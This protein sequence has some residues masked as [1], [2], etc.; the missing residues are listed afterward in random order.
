MPSPEDLVKEMLLY[1]LDP[2]DA[3]RNFVQFSKDDTT[4]LLINNFGG[5]SPLELEGLAQ[6]TLEQLAKDY[7]IKPA[8]IYVSTF[9]TS[10]NGPGFSLTLG[11]LSGIATATGKSLTDITALLDAPTNAPAWPRNHYGK[12]VQASAESAKRREASRAGA[13]AAAPITKPAAP[14]TFLPALRAACQAGI[15]AEPDITKYD[16]VMGDGDCGEGVLMAC[17]ALLKRFE[18]APF[19]DGTVALFPALDAILDVLED[20]GGSLFAILSIL[21]TAFVGNLKREAAG[22]DVTQDAVAK[23]A[24]AAIEN[25]FAYTGA[26]VGDRT[27]MDA[28]IPFCEAL[29]KEADVNKAVEAGNSG[30]KA[31][32]AMTPKFGR[33]TYIG[34]KEIGEQPPDPGAYAV[35]LWLAA[36]VGSWKA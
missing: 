28:L 11:N 6:V 14:A 35:A 3:E 12:A 1:V 16:M 7:S 4:C 22:G 13:D 23:A 9:E 32:A 15:K 20:M 33:A 25:L 8:R 31:T 5:L 34:D 24:G 2:N 26:R 19:T 29:G 10:L 18:T 30:A 36:L 21:A 27:C 17:E